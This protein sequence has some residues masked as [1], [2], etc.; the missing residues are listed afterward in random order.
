MTFILL[1]LLGAPLGFGQEAAT[2][3]GT[4]GSRDSVEVRVFREDDL[5]TRAQLSESGTISMPLI[6]NVRI[7]GMSTD[8]AARLIEGK[9]RDGYLVRPEVTVSITSRVRKT[10]TVLGKVQ[11]PGVFRLDPNR[12]LTLA[13]AIGMAGGLQRIANSKKLTLTRRGASEPMII[14]FKDIASGR[15]KDIPLSDGDIINIP[16]SLF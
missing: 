15:L 7:A 14:N 16:E 13:E 5:T 12:S 8:S 6:G 11:S 1:A 3:S 10:V 2:A 9:L 4:I